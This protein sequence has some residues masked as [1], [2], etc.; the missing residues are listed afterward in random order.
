LILQREIYRTRIL[1]VLEVL[2]IHFLDNGLFIQAERAS[3]RAVIT[4]PFRESCWRQLM[5]AQALNGNSSQALSE[6]ERYRQFLWDEM[7]I[8]PEAAMRDLYR[9]I[10][11]GQIKPSPQGDYQGSLVEVPPA[12]QVIPHNI[13]ALTT[14]LIDR[15]EE[16]AWI[17][18]FLTDPVN[19]L[20]TITGEGGIGKTRLALEVTSKIIESGNNFGFSD[21]VY[22][23]PLAPLTHP[24]YI[25]STIAKQIG[26]LLQGTSTENSLQSL[27]NHFA[28][29]KMLLL[30]DNFEHLLMGVD[31]VMEILHVSP[32]IKILVTSREPLR[33]RGEQ[34]LSLAGLPVNEDQAS[35]TLFMFA[36]RRVQ[37]GFNLS[38]EDQPALSSILS[39]T[40]GIPLAIE[41]AATWVES[42]P[43]RTIADEIEHGLDL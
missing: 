13:S 9:A 40:Q 11:N 42:L 6:Y 14:P 29:K 16:L 24:D 17:T 10:A 21:G 19:R 27:C 30:L 3:R 38:E 18:D 23:V 12:S 8:E 26:F 35:H 32:G 31:I 20:I 7:S 5:I 33:L 36:A 41:I 39:L 15:E 25:V 2:S 34:I 37:P 4:D 1:E 28:T 22:Y 43:L